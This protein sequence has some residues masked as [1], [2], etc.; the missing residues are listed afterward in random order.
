LL[1]K[2]EVVALAEMMNF[3]GVI[4]NDKEVMKKIQAAKRYK[5]P[6]DGHAPGLRGDSLK[7]Y[8]RAGITTDHECTDYDEALEK[9]KLGMKIQ[10]REGSS[11]KNMKQLIRLAD[12]FDCMLVSDD[13]HSDDLVKGHVNELLRKAVSLG[14]DPIKAIR[15]VT[16][17]PSKH[18]H[19]DTGIIKQGKQADFVI[20]DDLRKFNV[21]NVFIDGKLAAKNRK[22]LFKASPNK[23]G[24]TMNAKRKTIKDFMIF[25]KNNNIKKIKARVIGIMPNQIV[26]KELTETLDVENKQV[27][28]NVKKDILK[29]AVVERYGHNRMSVAFA[30]GFG[31]KKGAIASSVAHDSHNIIVVGT[32][33]REMVDAVNRLIDMKGGLIAVDGKKS[34][35]VELPIAGLMSTEKINIINRKLKKINGFVKSLGCKLHAPFGTLSFMALL[36]IPELKISDK[37]LFDGKNF[38]F[39]ELVK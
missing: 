26:T 1:K 18:Y 33:N 24:N 6:I 9:A 39:V 10:I 12:S 14:L 32:N 2:K 35:K 27:L 37:G 16:L 28:E 17:I 8:F 30:K 29:I 15:S 3:P 7:K 31:L 20:V 5:K 19:L 23:L 11:A 38:N 21:K 36:V 25:L 22:V 4:F 34:V 13:K